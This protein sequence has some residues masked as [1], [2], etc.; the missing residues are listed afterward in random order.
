MKKVTYL[1]FVAILASISLFAACKKEK[2]AVS[3]QELSNNIS[4][5]GAKR[6]K[7]DIPVPNEG[8]YGLSL[9]ISTEEINI[10]EENTSFEV[11]FEKLNSDKIAFFKVEGADDYFELELDENGS[12]VARISDIIKE[13]QKYI[14]LCVFPYRPVTKQVIV[15]FCKKD[16]NKTKEEAK[17]NK[18]NYCTPKKISF[19]CISKT[20]KCNDKVINDLANKL[21]SASS[22]FQ[23]NP[24]GSNCNAVKSVALQLLQEMKSCGYDN[25]SSYYQAAKA[26]EDLDCSGL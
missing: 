22:T 2:N 15:Q 11:A 8:E 25:N 20:G 9:D 26:W 16:K 6:I 24:T 1:M 23:N 18:Q 21:I 5:D 3:S 7:G 14:G 13:E 19:N 12:P 17:A 4:I 10:D